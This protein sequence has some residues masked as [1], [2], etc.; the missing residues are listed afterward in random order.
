[1][2][3][4]KLFV[5]G[6]NRDNS[7]DSRFFGFVARADVMGEATSTFVSADPDRWLAPRFRRFGKGIE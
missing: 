7:R 6:D 5:L 4:D 3:Q 1:M 2:P